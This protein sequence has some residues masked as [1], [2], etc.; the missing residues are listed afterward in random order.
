MSSELVL[1]SN[2]LIP[3]CPLLLLSSIFPRIKAIGDLVNF[4]Y[5]DGS[6]VY[7]SQNWILEICSVIWASL[8]AQLVKSA[9]AM[10]E[11]LVQFWVG[12]IRW[13]RDRL[14]TPVF[15][16]FRGGSAGKESTCNADTWIA[17]VNN[18]IQCAFNY[19]KRIYLMPGLPNIHCTITQ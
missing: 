19:I 3:S 8:I 11:T 15:L 7:T 5:D 14:P 2:H 18:T 13:R 4:Y 16:G 17:I 1:S 9:P 6:Q 12:K 10:Q